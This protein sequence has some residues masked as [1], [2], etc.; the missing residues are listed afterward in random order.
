[1]HF[2]LR[3]QA[4]QAA[5][6][7]LSTGG[8]VLQSEV[9]H[10]LCCLDELS[11][12]EDVVAVTHK[13]DAVGEHHRVASIVKSKVR[14]L[15]LSQCKCA[16]VAKFNR[17]SV[18]V[19]RGESPRD[20]VSAPRVPPSCATTRLLD[21]GVKDGV[22]RPGVSRSGG[23]S[24]EVGVLD[25]RVAGR[26]LPREDIAGRPRVRALP[27]RRSCERHARLCRASRRRGLEQ[28]GAPHHRD[29]AVG[30]RE[31]RGGVGVTALR[32]PSQGRAAAND[33]R[34]KWAVERTR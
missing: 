10:E 5:L 25:V 31:H 30:A 18:S 1:M 17:P 20:T 32:A 7:G 34:D 26:G 2:S 27:P 33:I 8:H 22:V 24:P 4:T 9:T 6:D 3:H 14:P 28:R 12:G 11:K 29:A 16:A 15:A 19:E 13:P 23:C 21:V